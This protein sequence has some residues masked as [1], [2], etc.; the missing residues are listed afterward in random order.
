MNRELPDVKVEFRNGRENQRSNGNIHWFTEK[1]RE[2]EKKKSICFVDYAKAF[3][4]MDHNCGK[5]FKK[6]EYQTITCLQA[7]KQQLEA[8][9]EQWTGSK[10]GK[11]SW[12]YIVT[13]LI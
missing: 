7:K 6:W 2:F 13:L 10:L 8:D 1:A 4:S 12:L 11:E 3:D 5:F 9:M